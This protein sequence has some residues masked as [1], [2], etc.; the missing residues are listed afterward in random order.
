VECHNLR[1]KQ[2]FFKA[3]KKGIRDVLQFFNIFLKR[4]QERT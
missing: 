2:T 4:Y 3:R 1:H